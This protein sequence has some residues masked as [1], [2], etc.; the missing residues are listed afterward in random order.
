MGRIFN[1]RPALNADF[2]QC[3]KTETDRIFA[4]E[5]AEDLY[6]YLHNHIKA[7]RPMVYFGTPTI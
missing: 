5:Q 2:V 6:V 1:T 4:V 7:T 3:D